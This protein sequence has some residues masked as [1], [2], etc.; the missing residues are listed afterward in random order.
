MIKAVIPL[1]LTIFVSA[2]GYAQTVIY[3]WRDRAGAVHIVDDLNKV[4]RD[5]R[6]DMKIYRIPSRRRARE[7]QSKVSSK[8][9]T[10]LEEAEE[11]ALEGKW[12]R[13]KMEEVSG[14]IT[15]LEERLEELKQQRE[16]QGIYIIKKRAKG[17]PVVRE[18]R[19]LEEIDREIEILEDQLGKKMEGLRLLEQEVSRQGGQ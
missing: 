5:Y 19:E 14:S 15:A 13:E 8:P 7:P 1:V 9:M 2:P 3:S 10:E 16:K 17:H 18:K 11:E 12:R 6:E 4:P